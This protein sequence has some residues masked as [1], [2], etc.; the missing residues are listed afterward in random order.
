M[1][2]MLDTVAPKSDQLN[3]DDLIGGRTLTIK[4]TK[5]VVRKSDEQPA[6]I[7]FEGDNGKTYK[8]CKSMR[9]VMV[10]VWGN[11]SQNY[12]GKSMTLYCD[13][14]VKFG[15][16]DV[17]GIRISHMSGLSEPKT[18]ALT[19]TRA[20]RKPFT[21]NPLV[22]VEPKPTPPAEPLVAVIA[23]EAQEAAERGTYVLKA[24]WERLKPD[25]QKK[26][27][28][29]MGGLKEKA[30]AADE[31]VDDPFAQPPVPENEGATA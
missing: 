16:K 3:A 4:I 26:I 6:S 28:H 8:P 13:P 15:G 31:P 9:R 21:V 17:G 24:F 20:S 29:L 12:V 22:V 25:Q 1:S 19:D 30:A 18:M 11:D 14:K 5:A 7:S 10:S 27:V 2:D 23:A